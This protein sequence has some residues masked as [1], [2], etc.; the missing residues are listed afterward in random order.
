MTRDEI[1]VAAMQGM[2][3]AGRRDGHQALVKA[4]YLIADA[5]IA[6]RGSPLG[7]TSPQ[8]HPLTNEGPFR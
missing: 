4:A 2:L 1:A 5:M 8:S 3:A 6:E 7:M